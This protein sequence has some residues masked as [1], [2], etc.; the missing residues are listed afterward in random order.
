MNLFDSIH[1]AIKK[2]DKYLRALH[3]IMKTEWNSLKRL[4]KI[5]VYL[6]WASYA[7]PFGRPFLPY[8]YS[9]IFR[10]GPLSGAYGYAE[11][12][13]RNSNFDWN[14]RRKEGISFSYILNNMAL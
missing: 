10:E 13:K 14:C 1:E 4:E 7:K 8:P 9:Y 2:Q 11:I 6:V 3:G 5:V 12:S